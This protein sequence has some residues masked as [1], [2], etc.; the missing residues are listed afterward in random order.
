MLIQEA[1]EVLSNPTLRREFDS[2]D[3]FDDTLP[4]ECSPDD[5]FKVEGDANVKLS[6]SNECKMIGVLF[7]SVTDPI[8]L[9]HMLHLV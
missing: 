4:S 8:L 1:Y 6:L 5:F 9:S 3:N 2:T 7:L